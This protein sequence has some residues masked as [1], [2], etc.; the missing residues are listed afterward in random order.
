MSSEYL[1]MEDDPKMDKFEELCTRISSLPEGFE[2]AP[3][4]LDWARRMI[5]GGYA[6]DHWMTVS[7]DKEI[8]I[9]ELWCTCPH[10]N[11]RGNWVLDD[12]CEY[13]IQA[14]LHPNDHDIGWNC[15]T[16][17]DGCNCVATIQTYTADYLARVRVGIPPRDAILLT[18]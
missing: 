13:H 8:Q 9:R 14:F 18:K 16:Y 15:P 7:S 12:T 11:D 5:Y 17:Y 6:W 10:P 4:I 3:E 1:K 2:D